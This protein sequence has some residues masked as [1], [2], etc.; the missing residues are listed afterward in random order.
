VAIVCWQFIGLALGLSA[1]GVPL[2]L[3]VAPFCEPTGQATRLLAHSLA[4]GRVPPAVTTAHLATV[5]R[6]DLALLLRIVVGS[7]RPLEAHR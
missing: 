2:S 1:V 3:G 5:G 7:G 4:A 6:P